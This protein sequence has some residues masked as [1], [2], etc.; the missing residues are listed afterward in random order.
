M[1]HFMILKFMKD[2]EL[3]KRNKC[4]HF[5]TRIEVVFRETRTEINKKFNQLQW[6][7]SSQKYSNEQNLS[8]TMYT[9]CIYECTK[10]RNDEYQRRT[11]REIQFE[12]IPELEKKFEFSFI[13]SRIFRVKGQRIILKCFDNSDYGNFKG[14]SHSKNE[15]L[16]NFLRNKERNQYKNWTICSNHAYIN[17]KFQVH[18]TIFS[19]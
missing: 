10:P 18:N 11:S 9:P 7:H 8:I 14:C 17:P 19:R 13:S 12:T 3:G 4:S 6:L 5:K 16:Y 1:I 15:G 2:S